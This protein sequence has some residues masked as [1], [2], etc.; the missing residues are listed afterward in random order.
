ML[1]DKLSIQYVC[2][3]AYFGVQ[4]LEKSSELEKA[5]FSMSDESLNRAEYFHQKVLASGKPDEVEST[6]FIASYFPLLIKNE[7]VATK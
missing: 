7:L 4:R 6:Q 5:G 3:G 1:S 2:N